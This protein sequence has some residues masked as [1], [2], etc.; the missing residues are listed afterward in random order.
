[1]TKS[2]TAPASLNNFRIEPL[3]SNN[4]GKFVGLFGER[5]A[6]GNCNHKSKP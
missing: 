3:T 5:G 4:W 6:C 1:M 2:K